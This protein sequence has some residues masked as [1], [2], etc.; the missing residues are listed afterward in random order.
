[1][2][3]DSSARYYKKNKG[4][5]Q[6][7]FWEKYQNLF[8]EEKNKKRENGRKR[9]KNFSENEKQTPVKYGETYYEMQIIKICYK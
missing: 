1:M 6:K 2:S 7:T 9:C 8:E 5:I 3:K 4:R